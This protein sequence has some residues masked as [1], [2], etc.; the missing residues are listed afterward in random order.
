M[1]S[2]LTSEDLGRV[3]DLPSPRFVTLALLESAATA[4]SWAG[5]AGLASFDPGLAARLLREANGPSLRL[6]VQILDLSHAAA[7]LGAPRVRRILLTTPLG[8]GAMSLRA[9]QHSLA[10]AG[11]AERL[12]PLAGVDSGAA[13]TAG[14][15]AELGSTAL[16]LA[17]PAAARRALRSAARKPADEWPQVAEKAFGIGPA[18]AAA[19]VG[20]RWGLPERLREALAARSGEGP[21]DELADLL[22][23]A[24]A[25]A[26]F[27]GFP[28]R[29]AR[30]SPEPAGRACQW[31]EAMS[32][33]AVEEVRREVVA[34]TSRLRGSR[35]SRGTEA[36]VLGGACERLASIACESEEA[37]RRIRT[38]NAALQNVQQRLGERDPA[39]ALLCEIVATLGFDRAILLDPAGPGRFQVTRA[40]TASGEEGRLGPEG[41]VFRLEGLP[42]PSRIG[43][44]D[45]RPEARALLEGLGVPSLALAP[46]G[47]A[48]RSAGLIAAD[49]G[50]SGGG[51]DEEDEHLLSRL[52]RETGVF[53]ENYRLVQAVRS[54]AV[55]D[56]LTGLANRRSI[57]ET[58]AVEVERARRT[59]RPLAIAM[60]DL[61][62]FKGINDSLGHSTGDAL[63]A[64]FA[65]LLREGLRRGDQV[66][67]YGGEEFLGILPG[68]DVERARVVAERIREATE[69]YG[70]ASAHRY[71]GHQIRVSV[72]IA[73][74]LG[75]EE[76]AADLLRRADGALYRA[77]SE[78]RN[79]VVAAPGRG[80]LAGSLP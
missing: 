7:V 63:L 33:R 13:R 24:E 2:P 25:A 65:G 52:A 62:H 61:D 23:A 9:W 73:A 51:I 37:S 12:A 8:L 71:E 4:S 10:R 75:E 46:L 43:R 29:T 11:A 69:A 32:R 18:A 20:R 54:L 56:G 70:R 50:A 27:A 59:R 67:R 17:D 49:R 45:G 60:F 16:A 26:W 35:R 1:R 40:V 64:D 36:A 48:G 47:S 44:D 31:L 5:L 72:G 19:D 79:R 68:A 6:R 14:L 58:L 77:K 53:L 39:D 42:L 21:C 57:M 38:L 41:A 76:T 30:G 34:T 15:L 74:L 22:R 80:S 55:T 28:A 66:G 78:G 3:R